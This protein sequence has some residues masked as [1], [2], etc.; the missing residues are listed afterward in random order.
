M[1]NACDILSLSFTFKEY[2]LFAT[3]ISIYIMFDLTSALFKKNGHSKVIFYC[4]FT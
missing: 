1:L 2:S 3:C 4:L